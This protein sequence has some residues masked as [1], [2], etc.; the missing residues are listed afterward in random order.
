MAEF[1]LSAFADEGGK[2]IDEQI[3]ALKANKLTAIE[4]RGINGIN[5]ADFTNEDAKKLKKK[6]DDNN[7]I[8]SALGS[9]FGKI[10]ITDDFEPH[11]EKF[12]T[13]VENAC[14]LGA[15]NI[16]I[17]SFFIEN[18]GL[19]ETYRDEVMERLDKMCSYSLKSGVWCCHENEK[20]IYGDT[21]DRCLDILTSLK[22]KIRGVFDPANFIQCGVEIMP[23]YKKLEPYIHYMHIKDALFSDGSVVPPGQGDGHIRELLT[24]FS[25]KDGKRFL[26]LEPHL[27]VFDGLAALENNGVT[28]HKLKNVFTY[29]SNAEAF[30]AAAD[31]LHKIL[32]DIGKA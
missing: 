29:G 20:D 8:V 5:I 14:I 25:K 10:K 7:I 31:A 11:F 13:A 21:D 9:P 24:E 27:K 17:F 4:P 1:I 30:A 6:L 12:K 23:A 3:E 18:A 26:T 28:A 32:E 22:G 16:R 15:E 19:C 2:T